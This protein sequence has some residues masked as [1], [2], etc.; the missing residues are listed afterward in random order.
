MFASFATSGSLKPSTYFSLVPG[1]RSNVAVI[2][3]VGFPH[4]NA[5]KTTV[6]GKPQVT[7][8]ARGFY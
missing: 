5:T 4:A 8:F 3:S 6:T 1:P 7:V 2:R